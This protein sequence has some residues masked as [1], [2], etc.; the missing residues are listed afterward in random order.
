VGSDSL[1]T[2]VYE[3]VRKAGEKGLSQ[4]KLWKSLGLTSREGSRFAIHLEK[5][6]K[7]RRKR[8]L[9]EGRWTY[10]LI[11]KTPP[12]SISNLL[13]IPIP[14]E[15][16]APQSPRKGGLTKAYKW[17]RERKSRTSR[18]L[19]DRELIELNRILGELDLGVKSREVADEAHDIFKKAI[20]A[21]LSRGRSI[22]AMTAAVIY[23]ACR[24]LSVPANLNQICKRARAR[25]KVVARFYR[26]MLTMDIFAVPLPDYSIH[27]ERLWNKLGSSVLRKEVRSEAVRIFDKAQ[28][29]GVLRGSHPA[30]I[31]AASLYL[32]CLACGAR[33]SQWEIAN[34]AGI[35][36]V[37]LR[38]N[39]KKLK[40]AL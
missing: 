33:L 40:S 16:T 20:V 22:E 19:L 12:K 21:D 7:I 1:K 28:S 29:I 4:A 35:T 2:K 38:N 36:E 3:V 10:R 11:A 6:D 26:K 5:R 23:A 14:K 39:Y 25:K 8:V 24:R 37:T 9:E 34:V 30:S 31:A 15:L 18:F 17:H 32:A 27:M 13:E